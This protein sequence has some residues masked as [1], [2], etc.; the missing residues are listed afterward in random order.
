MF[1]LHAFLAQDNSFFSP[2]NNPLNPLPSNRLSG[3]NLREFQLSEGRGNPLASCIPHLGEARQTVFHPLHSRIS[4]FQV[5]L[6]NLQV[7]NALAHDPSQKFLAR[8]NYVLYLPESDDRD[9]VLKTLI[10]EQKTG[11]A[12]HLGNCF[13]GI[14]NLRTREETLEAYLQ[15]PEAN[16]HLLISQCKG[17]IQGRLLGVLCQHSKILLRLIAQEAVPFFWRLYYT[18]MLSPDVGPGERHVAEDHV[19]HAFQDGSSALAVLEDIRVAI[20]HYPH[21]SS[22]NPILERF[23][24]ATM[25]F[26]PA[27]RIELLSL[28]GESPAKD[29]KALQ[30]S[31]DAAAFTL[32]QRKACLEYMSLS[33]QKEAAL[34][35]LELKG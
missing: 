30:L 12:S 17:D 15:D 23:I 11:N 7:L 29:Q 1:S 27:Q 26:T 33:S 28:M 35:A 2:Q 9:A 22:R 25:S 18:C 16:L 6:Y 4:K 24:D 13:L 5:S 3:N 8:A 32:E 31:Q 20:K 19:W 10:L 14:S 34:R 21:S